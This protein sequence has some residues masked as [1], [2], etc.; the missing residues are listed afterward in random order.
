MRLATITRP[1]LLTAGRAGALGIGTPGGGG[2][3]PDPYARPADVQR[4]IG[5]GPVAGAPMARAMLR[6]VVSTAGARERSLCGAPLIATAATGPSDPTITGA[7]TETVP[8]CL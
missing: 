6:A 1:R 4:M 7:A 8:G 5:M 2:R 3:A